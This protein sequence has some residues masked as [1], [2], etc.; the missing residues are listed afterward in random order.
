MSKIERKMINY[1][2]KPYSKL[3]IKTFTDFFFKYYKL[4]KK[5]DINAGNKLLSDND[6]ISYT[7]V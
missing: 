6:T 1:K 4:L 5:Y 2:L 3:Y 7:K